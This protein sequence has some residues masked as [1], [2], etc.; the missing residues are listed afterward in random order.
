MQQ[1]QPKACCHLCRMQALMAG[2][3]I[4]D[5]NFGSFIPKACGFQNKK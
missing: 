4:K 3:K 2:K 1:A 5:P